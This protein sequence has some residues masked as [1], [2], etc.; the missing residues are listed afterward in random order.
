LNKRL[1][2]AQD[3]VS[4]LYLDNGYLFFN[5]TPV[6]VL[7]ENDSI[8]L[9][10]RIY[11]GKQARINRVTVIGNTK[12][13]DHV[14]RRELKTVP[15]ELFSQ[16]AVQRSIRELATLGYF[17]PEKLNV[18]PQPNP[19][20]GTV[21]LEYIVEERPSDQIELSGGYGAGMFIG[22]LGLRLTNLA[23]GDFFKKG[24]W[25]PLPTGDG[26]QLNIRGQN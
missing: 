23:L 3:A 22:T 21:D 15:G 2:G 9:E 16:T 11:E 1:R 4:T 24:A 17:N 26:Q 8:D 25:R 6:E 12:T 19:V 14:I 18:N 7:I 10:M 5:V 13:H 20:D